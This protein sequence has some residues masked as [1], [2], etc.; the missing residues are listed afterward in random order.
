MLRRAATT[1][2]LGQED[3]AD[4]IAELEE[5]KLQLRIQSQKKNLVR[6]G[7]AAN[8]TSA[9]SKT[10]GEDLEP[11]SS[12]DNSVQISPLNGKRSEVDQIEVGPPTASL[13]WS[14]R[15]IRNHDRDR[16]NGRYGEENPFYRDDV[17]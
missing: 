11:G 2:Q 7:T 17:V 13:S 15:H 10:L 9:S 8:M 1:V 14:N 3:V 12:E 4:L 5:E 6:S 16:E